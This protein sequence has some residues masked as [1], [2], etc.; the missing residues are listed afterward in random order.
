LLRWEDLCDS[1][2]AFLPETLVI[3][4]G[5]FGRM[6]I[7]DGF[8]AEIQKMKITVHAMPT[9]KAVKVFNGLLLTGDKVMGAF[10][11]TC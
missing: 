4:R 11:L 10:H 1:I 6:R 9:D 5:K 2:R 7:D 8:Y 3:G